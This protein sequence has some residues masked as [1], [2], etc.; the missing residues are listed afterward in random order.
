MLAH[1]LLSAALAVT[2]DAP[3]SM[4]NRP[5]AKLRARLNAELGFLAPVSHRIQFGTDG[6]MFDYVDEGG[7]DN[8]FTFV[9]ASADLDIGSRH[10][11]VFL[12][13]PLDLRSEVVAARD[14]TISDVTF[15][16][17]T[18]MEL[19]YGFS[20]V[21]AS[22]LYD[23]VE[24]PRKEL[25]LGVSLQIRNATI[26][27]ASQDGSLFTSERDIG[28]VP[29]LKARG[30]TP[31]ADHAW[32]GAE[33]DGFYAPVSYLNGDDNDVIGAIIDGSLR[34]GV[35]QKSG[36]DLFVSLRSIAG[37]AQGY[38]DAEDVD[39]GSDGY[40]ENWLHFM[41]VSLGATLR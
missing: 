23:F 22:Y 20:F 38:S 29:I 31:I 34:V 8:L 9:R 21:R 5:D 36:T 3:E 26:D 40:T 25:A 4:L 6:T 10:S 12:F 17:G 11:V 41:T 19:R 39:S 18:P 24:G 2:P 30:R 14:V 15:P 35:A 7:Q 1:L 27:F 16:Q 33:V 37:G 13:Q 28:P 32:I